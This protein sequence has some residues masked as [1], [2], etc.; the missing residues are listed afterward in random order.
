[1]WDL[2]SFERHLFAYLRRTWGH[3]SPA[4]RIAQSLSNDPTSVSF[5]KNERRQHSRVDCDWP[6]SC[7]LSNGHIVSGRIIN[8]GAGGLGLVIELPRTKGELIE[9]EISQ[10]GSFPCQIAWA[11][12]YRAGVKFVDPPM[13]LSLLSPSK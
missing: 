11:E 6:A 8:A 12:D 10:I 3:S 7:R 5:Q 2:A 4:K 13:D 9:I 1:M